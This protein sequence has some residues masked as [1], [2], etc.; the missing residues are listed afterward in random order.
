M[1]RACDNNGDVINAWLS[2]YQPAQVRK[3]DEVGYIE[4][5]HLDLNAEVNVFLVGMG[6]H[7]FANKL[8]ETT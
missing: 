8:R 4:T 1:P 7:V 6:R 5:F 2:I 3:V